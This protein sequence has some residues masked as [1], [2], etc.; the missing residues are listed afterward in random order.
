MLIPLLVSIAWLAGTFLLFDLKL[1]L[2]SVVA[3]PLLVGLAIDDGI[4]ILHRWHE[5][6]SLKTVLREVGGPVTLTTIT[7]FIGFAGLSFAGHIGI[8]TLGM[9]AGLGLWLTWLGAVI[10]LPALLYALRRVA[11]R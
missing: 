5:V 1:N 8:K 9:T 3:F 7:T 2:Y 6:K 4:H 11:N 10:T